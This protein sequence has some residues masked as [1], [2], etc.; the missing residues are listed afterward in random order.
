LNQDTPS[1]EKNYNLVIRNI[2]SKFTIFLNN[3]LHIFI[4]FQ[5]RERQNEKEKEKNL[6]ILVMRNKWYNI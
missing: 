2:S 6:I 4:L 1:F 3:L 5:E